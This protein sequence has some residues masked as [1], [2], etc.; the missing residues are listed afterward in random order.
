MQEALG[1]APKANH[2]PEQNASTRD[3]KKFG[4][5]LEPKKKLLFRCATHNI[6]NIPEASW[7]AKSKEIAAMAFGKDGADIRIWQEIGLYWPNHKIYLCL[8]AVRLLVT[9]GYV[10]I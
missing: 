8:Q 4:N 2:E 5:K 7:T 6:N 10:N 3:D 1:Q 9:G